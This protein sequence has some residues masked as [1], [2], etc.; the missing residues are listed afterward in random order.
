MIAI[1]KLGFSFKFLNMHDKENLVVASEHGAYIY[2]LYI[3]G[4]AFDAQK[5][6]LD[7]S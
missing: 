1:D 3:E 2:G 6:F 5:G 4:C 7:D